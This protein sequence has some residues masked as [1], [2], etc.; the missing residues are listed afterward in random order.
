MGQQKY[1]DG[2]TWHDIQI[3]WSNVLNKPD[4]VTTGGDDGLTGSFLWSGDMDY[5]GMYWG[6][7]FEDANVHSGAWAYIRQGATA[8]Q[9]EIGSDDKIE[10]YETDGRT[11][12]I[13]IST[14]SKTLD[15]KG[16]LLENGVTLS[17][18]YLGI[19]DK[20]DDADKLDGNTANDFA[21]AG[22]NDGT[23]GLW[24]YTNPN[25]TA[26][27][28]GMAVVL[29]NNGVAGNST[30]SFEI[31]NLGSY[32]VYYSDNSGLTTHYNSN[33]TI[34]LSWDADQSRWYCHD[35]YYSADDYRIRWQY[36]VQAGKAIHGYQ[37]L[38]EGIDGKFYPVT[39]G[40][41]T[42]NTNVVSTQEFRLDGTILWYESGTDI[43]ADALFGAYYLYEGHYSSNMEYWNNRD[44]GWATTG[45]ALYLVGTINANGNFVLDNTS[46]TSFLTQTLPTTDDGKVYV[47][48]G[49]MGDNN[50]DM[51]L[52]V[53]HPIYHYKDSK[54]R[55]YIHTHTHAWGDITG[56]PTFDNYNKWVLLVDGDVLN[57]E[58]VLSGNAVEF[59]GGTN[60][61]LV[62]SG[63]SITINATDTNTQL[64][65]ENVQ[66]I[67]GAMINVTGSQSG[68]GFTYNDGTGKL[69]IDFSHTHNYLALSGGTLTGDLTLQKDGSTEVGSH[70]IVFQ[71]NT[72]SADFTREL[73]I[74]KSGTL[75][76][77]NNEVYHAG[78]KPSMATLGGRTAAEITAEINAVINGAPGAL[79]TLNE[80]AAAL[81]DDAN[82]AA[83]MT[84]A[85]AE[86]MGISLANGYE[87]M[88]ANGVDNVWIR[89]TTLGIIPYN[90][91]GT[92]SLGTASWPFNKIYANE[93][94]KGGS[95]IGTLYEAKNSNIQAHIADTNNP[96]GLD[97]TDV[98]AAS[99]SHT[100]SAYV[101][102]TGDEMTGDLVLDKDGSTE[103][104]SH[105]IVF[106][107]NTASS[108][109]TRELNIN[110]SGQ[111]VFNGTVAVLTDTNTQL[112]DE[113][114]Q[115]IVGAMI[116]VTGAQ[117]GMGITY[118]D[119]T[120][121]LDID[122]S[123]THSYGSMSQFYLQ[124]GDGTQVTIN[125]SKYLKFVEGAGIDINFTDTSTGS[126]AD[127]FDITFTLQAAASATFGGLKARV[128][129]NTLYLRNDGS[130]A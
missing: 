7:R 95:E 34:I 63:K 20:A 55:P 83:T 31:N 62:Q 16:G 100:H 84:N 116:N 37:L 21:Y 22:V 94:Y 50:D 2:G 68:M 121:K 12:A 47:K 38:M 123:H 117:S 18:K 59:I 111:L 13:D 28:D 61:T 124:D 114:V 97:Y 130:S 19:N 64:S 33:T 60:V 89:T 112:S 82:F 25:I 115:D 49:R 11:L 98:G 15:A 56:E 73:N 129:G 66:D 5:K 118:N 127:P 4:V 106:R 71:A 113:Q 99:S 108:D 77:N 102:T 6:S 104:G 81:G 76:F 67:V 74:N 29:F 103:V 91:G 126:S 14:N 120:G 122:F 17:A 96:H 93:I 30:T 26:L 46:Y 40:G 79:D 119:T 65:T 88:T 53:T 110:K 75:L 41:S 107:A 72:A 80:L 52:E 23:T 54:L 8:G 128:S 9:L 1:R 125:N 39:E 24:H 85:L 92:S 58:D 32:R 69:D 70:G 87:G 109:F 27:V 48:L 42:G 35:F 45:H 101:A 86:K 44:S 51:R 43:A 78:N 36:N 10:I 57:D 105:G 3:D 90:S